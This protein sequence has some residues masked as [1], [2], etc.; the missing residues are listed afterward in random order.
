MEGLQVT[1]VDDTCG[2][3]SSDFF[4][5]ETA[6]AKQFSSKPQNSWLPLK[7]NDL[8][9]NQFGDEWYLMHQND[10]TTSRTL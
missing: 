10:H 1:Q 8:W 3:V 7:F 2:G 5:L 4:V 6:K 9:I